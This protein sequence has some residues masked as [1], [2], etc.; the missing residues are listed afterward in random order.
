MMIV[1]VASL[2]FILGFASTTSSH[3]FASESNAKRYSDGYHNGFDAAGN[4]NT[5]NPTCDPNGQFTSD[6]QHTTIYCSG[7]ADGYQAAWN[8]KQQPNTNTGTQ[9][10]Q[11]SNV[12]IH[13]DNNRVQVNQGQ[14]SNAGNA[15][16]P[17][18]I[19]G[20]HGGSS[21]NPSCKIVCIS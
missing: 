16:S 4:D 7:W 15:F 18:N 2:V 12:N 10:E 8:E 6:G 19:D 20:H 11:T 17:D 14:S 5:Y 1:V 9:S 13:G 3:A 21:S